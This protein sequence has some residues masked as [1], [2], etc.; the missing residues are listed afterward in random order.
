MIDT[1]G[2][3]L[4]YIA[5]GFVNLLISVLYNFVRVKCLVSQNMKPAVPYNL[6]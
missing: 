5:R 2:A 3:S 1:G 4:F 6:N